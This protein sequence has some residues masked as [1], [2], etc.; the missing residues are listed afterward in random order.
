MKNLFGFYNGC[1][2]LCISSLEALIQALDKFHFTNHDEDLYLSLLLQGHTIFLNEA[3]GFHYGKLTD[4]KD[5]I[6]KGRDEGFPTKFERMKYLE[7]ALDSDID[8]ICAKLGV[9]RQ[10]VLQMNM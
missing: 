8:S 3:G 7:E 5:F 6:S 9:T 1:Y 2:W 10:E 4:K